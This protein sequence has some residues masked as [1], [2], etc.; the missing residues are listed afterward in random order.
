MTNME[1]ITK[2]QRKRGIRVPPK[3]LHLCKQTTDNEG[4]VYCHETP[5][6]SSS[7]IQILQ[8]QL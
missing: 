8:L 1:T 4:N 3:P 6:C 7:Y 2:R 5:S